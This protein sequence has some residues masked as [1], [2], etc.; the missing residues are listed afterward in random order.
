MVELSIIIV[1]FNARAFLEQCLHSIF[2]NPPR[3]SFEVIVID[4]GSED[5]S[6]QMVRETFP[7]VVRI[8]NPVDLH[9]SKA[10]NQGFIEAR[11]KWLY[12][13]NPDTIVFPETF[14]SIIRYLEENPEIGAVG[15]RILNPD[16]SDQR[17]SRSFPTPMST[18]F[19][20]RSLLTKMFPKNRF[21]QKYMRMDKHGPTEPYEVDW[22][23]SAAM[24]IRRS[25]VEEIGGLDETFFYWVDADWCYRIKNA[26]WK[27]FCFSESRVIH[28]E[29]KGSGHRGRWTI[30]QNTINFHY[31][32]YRYYC[33]YYNLGPLK[34]MKLVAM[35]GLFARAATLI[36]GSMINGKSPT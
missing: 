23:S 19:G 14:D 20:R 8:E 5:G 17:A 7:Q 13:L 28:D 36:A 12:C 11:G 16:L 26:G 9:Y 33:R 6:V 32:A 4:N 3:I 27:V 15:N 29:G 1:N 10:T 24:L 30:F 18:L 35:I 34:I 22:L 25:V 31:G 2:E 21:S